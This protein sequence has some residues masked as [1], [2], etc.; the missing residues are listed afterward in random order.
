MPGLYAAGDMASVPHN[1]M[2]GRLRQRRDRRREAPPPTAPRSSCPRMIAADVAAE[3]RARAAR[4]RGARTGSRPTRW[5][6]RPAAWSTTTCSR[7]RSRRKISIGQERL[8]EVR[9]DLG[10]LVR[11]RSARADARA[12]DP[13]DP[14]LRRDGGRAPRSTAP[15]AAGAST[16]CAS[17]IPRPTTRTGSATACT[18]RTTA[19]A[20]PTASGRSIPTSCRS[21]RTKCPPTTTCASST[22]VAAE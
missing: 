16:I 15:R 13:V 6:T 3:Q 20:S 14:R 1:Y 11:A 7:R 21:P 8:A 9:E 12:G 5:S 4:R 10:E 18:T 22:P 17:T 2:L 19:A